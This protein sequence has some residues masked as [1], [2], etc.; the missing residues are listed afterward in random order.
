MIHTEFGA[1]SIEYLTN[2]Y[3]LSLSNDLVDIVVAEFVSP[4]NNDAI[5]LMNALVPIYSS[6]LRLE[7]KCNLFVNVPLSNPFKDAVLVSQLEDSKETLAIRKI[8]KD[9][10]DDLP[11]VEYPPQCEYYDISNVSSEFKFRTPYG[12]FYLSDS[13]LYLETKKI[14]EFSYAPHTPN[15]EDSIATSVYLSIET[16]NRTVQSLNRKKLLDVSNKFG[17]STKYVFGYD[18]LRRA[19]RLRGMS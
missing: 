8:L 12:I 15:Q 16:I 10:P 11:I 9:L 7:A 4:E 19:V 1:Y 14:C 13:A 2:K 5:Y 17:I 6:I 3:V 18:R